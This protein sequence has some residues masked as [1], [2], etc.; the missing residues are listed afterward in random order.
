M[1]RISGTRLGLFLAVMF[2][3][4]SQQSYADNGF[5]VGGA[6]GK[7]Y[8]D[9]NIDG[10]LFE[11]NATSFRISGGYEFG[12]YFGVEAS[13]LDLGK[14]KDS[15]DVGGLIVP[16][17]A[18]ADGFTI[19]AVGRVPLS[20]RFSARARAGYFFSET[21]AT[22][23]GIAE[24]SDSDSDPFVGLGL[25]YDLNDTVQLGVDVDYFDMDG[26]DP[27]LASVGF[28]VRF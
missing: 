20:E 4:V 24:G 7:A 18:E 23:G 27:W 10:T 1:N 26:I 21:R 15:F 12:D 16:V 3:L 2:T 25:A 5:Y 22:I 13:Y 28:R 9:E 17:S 8:I 6:L 19:A 14:F 11:A